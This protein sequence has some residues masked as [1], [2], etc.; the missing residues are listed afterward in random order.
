MDLSCGNGMV[1]KGYTM[2]KRA[3]RR[4]HKRRMIRRALNSQ[5]LKNVDSEYRNEFAR[6]WAN[7]L[8]ICSCVY[9]CGNVRHN[10]WSSGK[11]RLTRQEHESLLA[12]EEQL[13]DMVAYIDE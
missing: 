1:L 12:I 9:S 10:P 11:V 8:K 2:V 13:L 3:L 5:R 6:K 4:H 7:H